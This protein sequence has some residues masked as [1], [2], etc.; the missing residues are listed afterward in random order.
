MRNEMT[1]TTVTF[2]QQELVVKS[3]GRYWNKVS[4]NFSELFG[5]WES[6]IWSLMMTFGVFAKKL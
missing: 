4:E 3:T 1:Y 2:S 6:C 5:V